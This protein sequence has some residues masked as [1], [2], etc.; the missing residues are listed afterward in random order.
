[1]YLKKHYVTRAKRTMM[2]KWSKL[3]GYLKRN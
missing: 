3:P 2:H 1:M